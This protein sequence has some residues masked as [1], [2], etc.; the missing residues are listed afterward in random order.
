MSNILFVTMA[1]LVTI[2][3]LIAVHEFGHFWVAK[4][5]GVKVLRFSIGFGR[6]LWKR[7]FG[8]DQTEYVIAALPLGGYVKMLD[9]REGDVPAHELDRAFNRQPVMT[10]IAI[11]AAG[12]IFNLLFAIVAYWAMF[13]IGMDDIKPVIGQVYVDSPASRAGLE[14]NDEILSVDGELTPDRK[15]TRLNSSHIPLSRMPSSA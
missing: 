4:K 11:V 14:K 1:F 15:S 5:L 8:P 2:S 7:S 10:R 13:S 6:P 3:V 12:P 9:E